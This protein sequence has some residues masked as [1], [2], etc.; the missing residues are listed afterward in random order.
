MGGE[1]TKNPKNQV[2]EEVSAAITGST[3]VMTQLDV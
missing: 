2:C 1:V 3:R